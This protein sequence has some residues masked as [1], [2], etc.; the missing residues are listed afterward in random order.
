MIPTIRQDNP[1]PPFEVCCFCRQRTMLWT[2]LPDRKEGE[3][4]A[5]CGACA[6]RAKPE[7]VPTKKQ[8]FR[9]EEIADHRDRRKW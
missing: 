6:E 7:D 5:C 1:Q 4:V 9:R 3:Q 2:N 8:W